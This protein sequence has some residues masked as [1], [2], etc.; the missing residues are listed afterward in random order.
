MNTNDDN[1]SGKNTST[2]NCRGCGT[3]CFKPYLDDGEDHVDEDDEQ[4]RRQEDG[5][6]EGTRDRWDRLKVE[7]ERRQTRGSQT[8]T[9]PLYATESNVSSITTQAASRWHPASSLNEGGCR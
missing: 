2:G 4:Q 8:S 5:V 3:S 7:I 6:P 9:S 1:D